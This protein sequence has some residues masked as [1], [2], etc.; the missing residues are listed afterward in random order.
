MTGWVS[1]LQL[2][3]ALARAVILESESRGTHDHIVLSQIRDSPNLEG[4]V[5]VFL[6]PR[7]RV[8]RLYPQALGSLFVASYDSQSY[9][10]GIRTRFHTGSLNLLLQTVLFITHRHGLHRKHPVSNSKSIVACVFISAGR[11]L[12]SRCSETVVVYMPR[13]HC[14]ATVVHTTVLSAT[15]RFEANK[16]ST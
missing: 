8:A 2:L 5:L 14:K 12:P 7:N 6:S 4:Q 9:C 10:G 11:C 13:S 16:I 3:L 1:R 15:S